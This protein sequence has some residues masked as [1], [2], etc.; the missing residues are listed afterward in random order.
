MPRT[1]VIVIP[2]AC[3]GIAA[4]V[5]LAAERVADSGAAATALL[6]EYCVACHNPID[7]AGN[8]RL[9]NKNVE[10]VGQNAET[11]EH[12][13]RKLKTGMMPPAGRRRPA[14]D[15]L[16][17][18]T[19]ELESRLDLAAAAHPTA[20]PSV[21]RRL[22]R[23]EYGNAIRD[24][25]HLE[26]DVATLLPLDDS[27][28]G[29]DNIATA[30]GV[31]PSLVESYVSAAMKISR[32]ALGDR[33]TPQS[34]ATYAAPA[35]LTQDRH[36]EG[37]PLGTRGGIR[38]RHT[39]PLDA[40]YRFRVRRGFRFP[41]GSRVDV[42][43]DGMPIT[44]ENPTQFRLPV[45]AGPHVLTAAVVDT[46]RPAGVDDIY[47]EYETGGAIESIEIDGPLTPTGVG[48]T[49][50]RRR[51][52][53]CEPA[54]AADE[55]RCAKEIIS[56]VA[57]RAFRRPLSPEGLAPLMAFF[58]AGSEEG[59]FEAGVQQALSRILVDPRFL[60]RL[61]RDPAT[62]PP[63]AIFE[64]GDFDLATRLSFFLWSSIP[65]DEL[66]ATAAAGG[67]RDSDTLERE[68]E[69]M[70]ADPKAEALVENFAAQWLFLRELDSVTP[71]SQ[72]FDENLR[73][74][75]ARETK[76]LFGAILRENMSIFRLL[77]ADFTFV[78]E[79][80]AEHYG[81]PGV[82][83]SHFR[84]VQIPPDNP[85]RGLLGHASILT[86]TSVTNRT[87]P[88]IRGSWILESLLGSPTPIPPPNVETTLE[89]D[90]GGV[91]A[92]SVRERLE[93]HRANPTCASCHAIMDPVGFSLENF[94]LVGAWRDDDNGWPIDTRATL[95][96][97]TVID[98]PA[99]LRAALLGRSDAFVTVAAEKLLTYA[100]GR[101][102][103][104]YDMPAVRAIVR[105]AEAEDDR[106]SAFILAV[107]QSEPFRTRVKG[108]NN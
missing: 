36:L 11:W 63:G 99:A 84:R 55:E 34:Q 19:R 66:L 20:G 62:L 95:A 72:L 16:D 7:L 60:Y 47:A 28:D 61:E 12:V 80:L 52:L 40:E 29:F 105:K 82:Y 103:D 30:L 13:V 86:V 23:T 68:V 89:G 73:Q 101:S 53:I 108:A 14:R 56:T 102:L 5:W 69:R 15:R 21:L 46:R 93:A 38:V 48:D 31:S 106:L 32:W 22:N 100:L 91:V 87:S 78:D 96:D 10:Q 9:D 75:M 67:L 50:S 71:D 98:G 54:S 4:A 44:A 51:I 1:A 92:A 90:D 70:L 77:D 104:Y 94:D 8:L 97:G 33:T 41:I 27:S 18:L 2:I 107:A 83:G 3:A 42:T 65:D 64:V 58:E 85:R 17:T 76:L 35:D 79:R 24:V 59:G 88:V 49:P 57:T 81:I 39:F 45:T 37:M 43:L 25:L 6:D 74:A 26:V